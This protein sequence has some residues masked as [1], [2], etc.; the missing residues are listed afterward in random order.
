ME[1]DT[2]V[3]QDI[4]RFVQEGIDSNGKA[5]GHFQA[6]GVRPKCVEHLEAAGVK[7]PTSIFAERQLRSH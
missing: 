1:Q 7:L 4:F 2:L 5:H 6:T 3:M